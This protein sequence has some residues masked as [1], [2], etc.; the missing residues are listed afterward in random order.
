MLDPVNSGKA[1]PLPPTFNGPPAPPAAPAPPPPEPR[2]GFPELLPPGYPYC[3]KFGS[4]VNG[5]FW[6]G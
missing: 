4:G 5:A 3:E 2:P 1:T 6:D